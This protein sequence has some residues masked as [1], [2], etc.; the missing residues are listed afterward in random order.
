MDT[1]AELKHLHHKLLDYG[2]GLNTVPYFTEE[3]VD[4]LLLLVEED[5]LQNA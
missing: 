3:E 4:H 5:I 1:I 2:T